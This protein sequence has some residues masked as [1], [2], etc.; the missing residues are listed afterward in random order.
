MRQGVVRAFA[1]VVASN[2]CPE[3]HGQ[4][5]SLAST[6]YLIYFTLSYLIEPLPAGE[7]EESR[8]YGMGSDPLWK[9]AF[10]DVSMYLQ[11]TEPN[12]APFQ[13]QPA[14]HCSLMTRCSV[15]TRLESGGT[16]TSQNLCSPEPVMRRYTIHLLPSFSLQSSRRWRHH[17]FPSA[18]TKIRSMPLID[19]FHSLEQDKLNA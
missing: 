8:W 18:P 17:C 15:F 1:A 13:S 3:V 9:D 5:L 7:R 2:H 14:R 11:R 19:S 10:G 12:P 16:W 4:G 6:Q